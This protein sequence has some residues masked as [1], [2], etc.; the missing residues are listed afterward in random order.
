MERSS[1]FTESSSK[2]SHSHS[3]PIR[4]PHAHLSP[5]ERLERLMMFLEAQFGAE[6]VEPIAVPKLLSKGAAAGSP[7]TIKNEEE[8]GASDSSENEDRELEA[9][10]RKE[11]ERLHKIGIPVPGVQIKVDKTIAKVWLETLEVECPSK[12]LEQ[13]I[14]TVVERAVEVTAP[15]WS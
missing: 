4:N 3:L 14:R 12:V 8:D 13:R 15:L 6:N 11:L 9:L 10:L 7:L 2:H 1:Q 5:T